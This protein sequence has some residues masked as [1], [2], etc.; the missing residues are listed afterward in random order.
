M[1]NNANNPQGT[2]TIDLGALS[3]PNSPKPDPIDKKPVTFAIPNDG[4]FT[5]SAPASGNSTPVS[6]M[7]TMP[8]P[9]REMPQP[10]V[11]VPSAPPP[12]PQAGN[13]GGIK[14]FLSLLLG[15]IFLIII[16]FGVYYIF[17]KMVGPKEVTLTYWG[18]WENDAI[19]KPVIDAF[20]AKNPKIKINY[21]KQSQ[22]QYRERLSAAIGRGEGPD[23][24]RFHN[25]WIPMLK[26]DLLT[27]PRNIMSVSEFSSLFYP[28]AK[29]DLVGGT[30]I[31][32]L[33][34]E[35]DGLG[36]YVNEDIFAAAGAT[37]PTLWDDFI[38]PTGLV[39]KLTVRDGNTITTSAIAL[40]T[41]NNVEHFSDIIGLMLMQNGAKLTTL[42]G[43]EAEEALLF[44]RKFADPNDDMYTWNDT[45]DNSVVAFANG[46]VAM[47]IAPSWRAFD[48]KQLNP[49]LNFRIV[50]VPQ[51]APGNGVN[52][53]SYWVEGVSAKTK[54]PAQAWEFIKYLTSQEGETSLY[55]S[56]A[57]Y[58]LFGEPYSRK[59]LA[60]SV[61]A[62]KYVNAYIQEAPTA[63]S[64][65]LCSRT[66]DNGLNDQMIKYIEDAINSVASGTA[67][68][69]ALQTASSGFNQVLNRYGLT[70]STV[71]QSR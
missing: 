6:P 52:W 62:D 32:G 7:P 60:S 12:P 58:R 34:V 65:P 55:T 8:F 50:P 2:V 42:T 39:K 28:V 43:K 19:I 66:F 31:Y 11:V 53:A 63:R 17:S 46:R 5:S 71:P 70:T 56:A 47:I 26:N 25:T 37:T 16:G 24:F 49:Q 9:K 3:M 29:N 59:D 1:A 20:E 21:Q 61:A 10:S 44:Y 15:I 57:N 22:K 40:G 68:S 33:P 51:L 54:Y 67:P 48:I 64:F 45:L 38:S 13:S 4:S 35:I 30:T 18:L 23:V 36:L 69:A 27:A 41:T 14:K